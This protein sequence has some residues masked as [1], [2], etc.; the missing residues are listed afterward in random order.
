MKTLVL[1]YG[2]EQG[3]S[4]TQDALA[5]LCKNKV[6]MLSLFILLFMILIAILTPWIAPYSYEE[7]NLLLGASPPSAEHWLGTDVLGRDQLTRIMYGSQ[8]SLMVGFIATAVALTIGVLWGATAG[9]LGGR[10]DAVMM[11]IVDVLYALPFTIFIILLTV[12]FGSS[13]LLLFLA[14]GAVEW[15]T[16]A[17]IV[18]GQVLNIKRQ[19]FVEAAVAMGLSPWQ[20]ISRHLIPNVLGPI[21]VY[22]TLT[23]PSVILLES[24]LSFLGL[25][26]QPPAS[27]WGSL[28]SGGVET[29]EEYPWLI[30]FPGL[31]LTITLFSLNFLGDGLRDALDP[32]TSKD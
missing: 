3:R 25:G 28:I 7:Q 17:R 32:R 8:V 26:I 19:E 11:R 1:E 6:A 31:V 30:L 12:I 18:R 21:I 20:I 14:I 23:I 10:V 27:S 16:M 2:V 24:F 4:L 22:T 9:F 15:L 5:R 29:M 13:M